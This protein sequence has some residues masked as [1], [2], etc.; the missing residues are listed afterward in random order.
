MQDNAGESESKGPSIPASIT[1]DGVIVCCT[2]ISKRSKNEKDVLAPIS[3]AMQNAPDMAQFVTGHAPDGEEMY[4]GDLHSLL[5][6]GSEPEDTFAGRSHGTRMA[7]VNQFLVTDQNRDLARNMAESYYWETIQQR[8]KA[9][10]HS[11]SDNRGTC[12]SHVLQQFMT[13]AVIVVERADGISEQ[14]KAE[15]RYLWTALRQLQE[16]NR[17][18]GSAPYHHRDHLNRNRSQCQDTCDTPRVVMRSKLL[19]YYLTCL[20]PFKNF[21]Q[22]SSTSLF[23]TSP[24][25]CLATA[26][27][28]TPNTATKQDVDD[29]VEYR[30]GVDTFKIQMRE[31][32][33]LLKAENETIA[34]SFTSVEVYEDDGQKTTIV[35]SH[36]E[37]EVARTGKTELPSCEDI[38]SIFKGLFG[39]TS[40]GVLRH[41]SIAEFELILHVFETKAKKYREIINIQGEC[42]LEGEDG[43]LAQAA[44]TMDADILKYGNRLTELKF[45]MRLTRQGLT[46]MTGTDEAPSYVVHRMPEATSS[47]DLVD[48]NGTQKSDS[49]TTSPTSNQAMP[50]MPPRSLK[51]RF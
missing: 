38:R 50:R 37:N 18:I 40:T 36:I 34:V 12:D 43:E 11:W 16:R 27:S 30:Q 6:N 3:T 23:T 9:L 51:R 20:L 2:G 31:F 15:Y 1:I 10:M 13:A 19:V 49:E 7:L 44:Q 33:E 17:P 32:I 25:S 8:V 39:T 35:K 21:F 22:L 47:A 41:A 29:D 26:P 46:G 42:G 28:T 4:F 48:K 14:T 45:I 5:A 24:T